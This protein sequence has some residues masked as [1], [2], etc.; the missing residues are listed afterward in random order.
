MPAEAQQENLKKNSE[1]LAGL[2]ARSLVSQYE[3]IFVHYICR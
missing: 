2:E 3:A 1:K